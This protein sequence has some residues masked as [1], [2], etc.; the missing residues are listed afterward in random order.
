MSQLQILEKIKVGGES[1]AEEPAAGGSCFPDIGDLT[2]RLR[3]TVGDGNIRFDTQRVALVHLSTL[4]RLRCELLDGLCTSKARGILSRLGWESG[5]RDAAIAREVRSHCSLK[6]AFMTGPQLRNLQGAAAVRPVRIEADVTVGDF[7]GEFIWPESLEVESQLSVYGISDYPVCWIQTA[8]L[9]GYTSTFLGRPILYREVECRATGSKLCR[10]IGKP[11]EEWLWDDDLQEDLKALQLE[12]FASNFGSGRRVPV[13]PAVQQRR[14]NHDLADLPTDV[15]GQSSSFTGAYHLVKKVAKT[16]ATVL[17]L[18]ETGVGKEVFARTLH[19]LSRRQNG[20]FVAINCAAIPENLVE[21]ELFGVMRGSFTG[22][23]VSRPGRFERASGGTLFL[24]EVSSL[25]L[26]AQTKLLRA[27]QEREFERVGDTITRRSDVRIVAASNVELKDAVAAG[28]FRVDLQHR[29]DGFPIRLPP[30]RERRDDISLLVEHFMRRGLQ[31]H[32]RTISGFTQRALDALY[33]YDFPG[34]I[35]ELENLIERA[36]ILCEDN[37]RID[38]V[39]LFSSGGPTLPASL[40]VNRTGTLEKEVTEECR[41]DEGLQATLCGFVD[42]QIPLEEIEAR[43]L[44][45]AVEKA[46]GNLAAA[47]RSLGVTRAQLAYRLKRK[48]A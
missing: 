19:K 1:L 24:D 6:D 21:A 35:R 5:T 18:G 37:A 42:E 34:N 48:E 47:A 26:L 39:H 16:D 9:S 4:T 2:D 31:R 12:S 38:L 40:K 28:T 44:Q 11:V 22:A 30:L 45:I 23:D 46:G 10:A 14:L 36:V 17:F 33:N 43:L 8:Y 27:I 41:C 3:F 15:I 20:P 13:L 32:G 29:L 7:Y 25:T